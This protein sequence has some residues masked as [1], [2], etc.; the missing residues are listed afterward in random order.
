MNIAPAAGWD[1]TPIPAQV[2]IRNLIDCL[3]FPFREP[4]AYTEG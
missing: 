3:M 4:P 2:A 1:A